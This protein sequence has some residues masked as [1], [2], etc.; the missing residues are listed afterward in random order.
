[1]S[2]SQ[3]ALTEKK[4]FACT[5]SILFSSHYTGF[6][7]SVLRLSLHMELLSALSHEFAFSPFAEI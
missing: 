5:N 2:S 1:M 4:D 3:A 7:I 6:L